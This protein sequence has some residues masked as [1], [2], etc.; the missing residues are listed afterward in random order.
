MD[1][2]TEEGGE[3]AFTT[4]ILAEA[5]SK[6][7]Y[8]F[9]LG[10]GDWWV[11]NEDAPTVTDNA[12]N[13]NN[14]AEVPS[15]AEPSNPAAVVATAK[16]IANNEG[17]QYHD[18]DANSAVTKD[19]PTDTPD[20]PKDTPK[21]TPDTLAE[22]RM[23]KP[24][25]NAAAEI[26]NR[27]GRQSGINTPTFV[28]V[29]A[30]VADSAAMLDKEDPEPDIPDDEAGRIGLRR[31]SATPI[32]EVAA[33]AA[34]VANTAQTLDQ[35]EPILTLEIRPAEYDELDPYGFD[36]PYQQENKAPLFAH[37]CIGMYEGEEI[38]EPHDEHDDDRGP[39][40]DYDPDEYDLNDPT[41]ERFPSN[42]DDIIDAVRKL[43]GGLN[44]DHA[45]VEG[46]VPPSPIMGSS[47]PQNHDLLG[48]FL[49]ASPV[50][51]SPI[52]SR[53]PRRLG[54]RRSP[55][56]SVSSASGVSL[57]SI[58]EAE[59]GGHVD[60][61]DISPT[62]SKPSPI[63]A[64][65]GGAT[66]TPT[67]D[68]DEG[69]VMKKADDKSPE[70][71]PQDESELR[72]PGPATSA[73]SSPLEISTSTTQ[74][75]TTS[76]SKPLIGIVQV[77]DTSR[78]ETPKPSSGPV[79]GIAGSPRI[80]IQTAEETEQAARNSEEP[81]ADGEAASTVKSSEADGG[82]SS[83]KSTAVDAGNASQLKKRVVAPDRAATPTSIR[84]TGIQAAKSGNW[85]RAFFRTVFVDW[86]GGFVSRLWGG[87]R[88][89]LL[90]AGAAVILVVAWRKA[91]SKDI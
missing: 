57:H 18:Q 10:L 13:R 12:G 59:E 9:R 52:M 33:T 89:T 74:Y 48:D 69:I 72:T 8:K 79:N 32:K 3:H 84:S 36:E 53:G 24:V 55:H 58:S 82:S 87:R 5:G 85:F 61:E 41:L 17:G 90:I 62:V 22:N 78:P 88:K 91:T 19:T 77:S 1:Y 64:S 14:V 44:E 27:S 20:T 81:S 60:E 37:E 2:T 38:P 21:D 25:A 80:V 75:T 70:S 39:G 23:L 6:V 16:M 76:D 42:R 29:A 65:A 49:V 56:G 45:D 50:V 4:A 46:L 11:L 66:K 73:K 34:E 7:Q 63:R 40:S 43:E 31:M 86:I 54:V 47:G 28:K 83:A 26:M 51:S 15:I 67:S 68:E 30:E 35:E 71:S